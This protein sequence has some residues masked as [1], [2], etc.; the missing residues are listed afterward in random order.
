MHFGFSEDSALKQVA[1]EYTVY[2][3][4]KSELFRK[5]NRCK[6]ACFLQEPLRTVLSPPSV[7]AYVSCKVEVQGCDSSA[8]PFLVSI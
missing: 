5:N 3:M 6:S 1:V 4:C 2:I 8:N 7:A